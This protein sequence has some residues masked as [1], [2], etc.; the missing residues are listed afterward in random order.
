MTLLSLDHVTKR[1]TTHRREQVALRDVSLEI[2][3]GEL[4]S[5]WGMRRSGRTTLLRIAAGIEAPDEGTVCF[6]GR[7]IGTGGSQLGTQIGY[8]NL[9]FMATQG[10]SVVEHIAVSLL[11]RGTP[12]DR[13]RTRAREMLD[14]VGAAACADLDAKILDPAE[15]VRVALARALA[16]EPRLLLVDDPTN[17]VDVLQRDPLL[18]LIRSIADAGTAVLLTVGEVVT[19]ADR[20]LSIDEGELHGEA[21]PE[22]AH[23]LPLRP[24][25]GQ[26]SA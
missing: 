23:V 20:A 1:Y 26:F 10:S 3:Y 13:A 24:A 2:D 8:T 14:R 7:D 25:Q 4:V 12:L 5:V 21:V 15:Q 11:A 17:G 6:G 19:I 18:A 22:G 9:N 16:S